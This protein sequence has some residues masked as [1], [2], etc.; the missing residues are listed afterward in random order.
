MR[1]IL[2]PRIHYQDTR[3]S[4]LLYYHNTTFTAGSTA[5]ACKGLSLKLGMLLLPTRC[6]I[7]HGYWCL[8]LVVLF[9]VYHNNIFVSISSTSA[10][11]L[12]TMTERWWRWWLQYRHFSL[13][14]REELCMYATHYHTDATRA[15]SGIAV[16]ATTTIHTQWHTS[17]AEHDLKVLP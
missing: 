12:N 7:I 10:A 6:N 17:L 16:A 2:S 8:N 1:A 3:A 11:S 5:S 15:L 14:I 4:A 13:C 9:R